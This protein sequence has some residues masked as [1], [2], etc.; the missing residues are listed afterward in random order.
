[1]KKLL[2]MSSIILSLGSILAHAHPLAKKNAKPN[3]TPKVVLQNLLSDK[4]AGV[5]NREIIVSRVVIPPNTTLP[6]H[7]HP[8]EEFAY[9]IK[10]TVTLWQKGKKSIVGKP[11]D[12]IKV[13]F[14][15]IHTAFTQGEA[16]EVLVFR[17]HET[18]KP[19]RYKAE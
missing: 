6:R 1:M 2:I 17:L 13:P 7:W 18:G 12:V 19:E 10:G 3:V 14:K 11:G 8:G 5:K 15:Q 9:V 16:A 4:I